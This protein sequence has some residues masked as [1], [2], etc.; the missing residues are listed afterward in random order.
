V[1]AGAFNRLCH[2]GPE[3]VVLIGSRPLPRVDNSVPT[4]RDG[5]TRKA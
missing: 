1:T 2:E 3:D 4:R 5:V